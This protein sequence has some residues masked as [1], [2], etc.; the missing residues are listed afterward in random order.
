MTTFGVYLVIV[1]IISIC[2]NFY[3]A[4]QGG[5]HSTPGV[6]VFAAVWGLLNLLGIIFIGTGLG[7]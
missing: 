7:V 5:S 4:G 6:L 2:A 3:Y 1:N